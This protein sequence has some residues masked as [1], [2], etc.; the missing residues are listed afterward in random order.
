MGYNCNMQDETKDNIFPH[1]LLFLDYSAESTKKI[2]IAAETSRAAFYIKSYAEY[3]RKGYLPLLP[4]DVL[5]YVEDME[6]EKYY[7]YYQEINQDYFE[8]W[9]EL[10]KKGLG[11]ITED[12]TPKQEE[13]EWL[14]EEITGQIF[15]QL[16][17]CSSLFIFEYFSF[18]FWLNFSKAYLNIVLGI[19]LKF[20]FKNSFSTFGFR[21][22][23]SRNIQPTAL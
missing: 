5:P 7:H 6:V 22:P 10:I 1:E 4:D 20:W 15:F 19:F 8:S 11:L 21:F 23:T 9:Q 18:S 13:K 3:R 17:Y 12:L 2:L 14:M 16:G